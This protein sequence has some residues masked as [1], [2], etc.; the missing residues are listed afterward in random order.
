MEKIIQCKS[1]LL[2]DKFKGRI[3]KKYSRTY[4]IEIVECSE[5]DQNLVEDFLGRIVISKK[6]CESLKD[7]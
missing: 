5:R 7:C 3:L 2:R 6:L 4:L 1:P